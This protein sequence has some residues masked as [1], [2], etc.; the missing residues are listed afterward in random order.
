MVSESCEEKAKVVDEVKITNF[1]V[2]I[3]EDAE[4]D[5]E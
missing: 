1:G 4:S 5:D 2:D 3:S